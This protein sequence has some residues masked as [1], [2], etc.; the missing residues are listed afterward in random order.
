MPVATQIGYGFA[1]AV[2]ALTV[3]LAVA[4]PATPK[5]LDPPVSRY[6]LELNDRLYKPRDIIKLKQLLLRQHPKIKLRGLVLRK[7]EVV[8]KSRLGKGRIALRVGNAISEP[9]TVPGTEAAFA[10]AETNSFATLTLKNNAGE[11]A[12]K[13]QLFMSGYFKVRQIVLE[14]APSRGS[15]I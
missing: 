6:D 8:A 11:Q 12:G 10:S 5:D 4:A 7:V 15:E 9:V 2:L 13:W 3:S 14:L 1:G